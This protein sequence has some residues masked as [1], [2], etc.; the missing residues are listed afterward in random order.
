VPA[1]FSAE[2]ALTIYNQQFAVVRETIPLDLKQGVN[3]LEFTGTTAQV[4][5]ESVM[6]RDP[7]GKRVLRILE[8]SYRADPVSLDALLKRYEGQNRVSDKGRRPHRHRHRQDRTGGGGSTGA[9]VQWIC[10]TAARRLA[11]YH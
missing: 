8:Q 6:L 9:M 2:P 4:E 5:P 11:T 10:A 1:C 3:Q 7:S